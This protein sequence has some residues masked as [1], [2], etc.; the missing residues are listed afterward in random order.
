VPPEG[1][2][3]CDVLGNFINNARL[4]YYVT[5]IS[6]GG[7]QMVSTHPINT[8]N[9]F[10]GGFIGDYTGLA[11]GSDNVFHAFWTDTNNKQSVIWFY[12]FEFVPTTINQEDVVTARGSW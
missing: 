1:R 12:G 2:I 3:A 6:S 5:N 4:N 7:T 10:G 9:G 8:R 11:V